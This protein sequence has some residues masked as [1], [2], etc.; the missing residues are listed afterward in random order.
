VPEGIDP[1]R[2]QA[3]Q[4]GVRI[5][6]TQRAAQVAGAQGKSDPQVVLL[7][8]AERHPPRA[9]AV[10]LVE[11]LDAPSA[12]MLIAERASMLGAYASE[13]DQQRRPAARRAL[14]DGLKRIESSGDSVAIAFAYLARGYLELVVGDGDPA[15]KTDALIARIETAVQQAGAPVLAQL[16]LELLRGQLAMLQGRYQQALIPLRAADQLAR[17][18]GGAGANA[19]AQR[20][21]A[22][23]LIEAG[24]VDAAIEESSA[25]TK[26][27]IARHGEAHARSAQALLAHA[28]AL[29]AAGKLEESLATR[30]KVAQVMHHL[31]SHAPIWT[32]AYML[33]LELHLGRKPADIA[34]TL[35]VLAN[36]GTTPPRH[37]P[38][39]PAT[40]RRAGMFEA[41]YQKRR[42]VRRMRD[43][44][45]TLAGE[46][47]VLFRMSDG[48]VCSR[49]R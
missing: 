35:R 1:Q 8:R 17:V 36:R 39:G 15:A 41:L 14:L 27:T 9:D 33:D 12:A 30:G 37:N 31:G 2:V 7:V 24:H 20:L 10:R 28:I 47:E 5:D 26:W 3:R 40:A 44:Q 6:G 16:G 42:L 19:N 13:G 29:D 21:L 45:D 43:D 46:L 22:Q 32:R 18:H 48:L 34:D 11:T 49:H 38:D 23:A 4:V 25:R